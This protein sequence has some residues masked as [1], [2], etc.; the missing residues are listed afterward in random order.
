MNI[1]PSIIKS[2]TRDTIPLR[3]AIGTGVATDAILATSTLRVMLKKKITDPDF[4]A[5]F[6]WETINPTTR[7]FLVEIPPT[8]TIEAGRYVVALKI[9]Y[10]EG[11]T[12]TLWTSPVVV[13]Q[14]VFNV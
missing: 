10:Q 2:T 3:I 12:Y 1:T 5:L 11:Q 14:G 7:D 4:K 13:T 6:T 9:W 8:A